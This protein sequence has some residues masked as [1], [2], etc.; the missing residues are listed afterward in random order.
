MSWQ[1]IGRYHS[2]KRKLSCASLTWQLGEGDTHHANPGGKS[3]EPLASAVLAHQLKVEGTNLVLSAYSKPGSLC[4]GAVSHSSFK[5]ITLAHH[6][7]SW[8][9]QSNWNQAMSARFSS[10]LQARTSKGGKFC[11]GVVVQPQ[12]WGLCSVHRAL[13]V[14]HKWGTLAPKK[15]NETPTTVLVSLLLTQQGQL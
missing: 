1:S 7:A 11:S 9:A 12:P 3:N 5:Q 10:I 13:G 15:P 2:N 4:I 8:R 14:H 6:M